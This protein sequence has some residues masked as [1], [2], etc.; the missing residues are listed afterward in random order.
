MKGLSGDQWIRYAAVLQP[1]PHRVAGVIRLITSK[2][3]QKSATV[4]RV[5]GLWL[6]I[7]ST[8]SPVVS[9]PFASLIVQRSYQPSC[10]VPAQSV[11]PAPLAWTAMC[12]LNLVL[13]VKLLEPYEY[14]K[15]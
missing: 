4:P 8:A 2:L 6:A 12:L 1:G 10:Y 9:A 11:S 15:A 7:S 14:L 5:S 13:F 3:K